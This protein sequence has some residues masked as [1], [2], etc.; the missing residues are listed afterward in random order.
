MSIELGRRKP[1]LN[2]NRMEWLVMIRILKKKRLELQE[3]NL[4]NAEKELFRTAK[5]KEWSSWVANRVVRLIDGR[6]VDAKRIIRSR[7]VLSWKVDDS[8]GRVAKARLVLLGYQDPDLGT[9]RADAPT[10]D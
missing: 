1:T 5:S 9:Y 6:G 3:R 2:L 4:T 7:W 10:S 8:G